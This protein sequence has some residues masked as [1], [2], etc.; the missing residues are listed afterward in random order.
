[1]PGFPD[2]SEKEL[3]ALLEYIKRLKIRRTSS[4]PLIRAERF[5]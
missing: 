4:L 5:T 2:L 3:N 1:M